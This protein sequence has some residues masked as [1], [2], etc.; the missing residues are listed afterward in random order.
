[1]RPVVLTS[2][3]K[4]EKEKDTILAIYHGA[5]LRTMGDYLLNTIYLYNKVL[6]VDL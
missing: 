6:K 1:M 4:E 3:Q 5:L 2:M